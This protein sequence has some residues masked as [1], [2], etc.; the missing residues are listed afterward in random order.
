V[1]SSV[2]NRRQKVQ[3][4]SLDDELV[5]LSFTIAKKLYRCPGC[6]KSIDVGSAHT[7]VRFLEEDSPHYQHWHRGC[8]EQQ[9]LRS[10][11]GIRTV[12]S[13]AGPSSGQRRRA[14]DVRRRRG[15]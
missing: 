12:P 9:I 8:A 11:K 3:G 14:A 10:L 4:R 5:E 13:P 1:S 6:G 15:R 2:P 7:L